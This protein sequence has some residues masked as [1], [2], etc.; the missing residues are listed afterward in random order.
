MCG[1]PITRPSPACCSIME[2]P[3][4]EN[5][6]ASPGRWRP[7]PAG[8]ITV[9]IL[10]RHMP[11]AARVLAALKRDGWTETRRRGSHRVL[12]KDDHQRIWAY[13]EGVDL[14]G[15]AMARIAK[16]Y[17]YTLAELRKL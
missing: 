16:D 12:V 6:R 2:R 4:S 1:E 17:G 7:L 14:G 5:L 3:F 15:P 9:S 13:H 11:K 8:M 10:T